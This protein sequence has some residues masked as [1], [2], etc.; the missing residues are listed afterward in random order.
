MSEMKT[1]ILAKNKAEEYVKSSMH[2]FPSDI[3]KIPAKHSWFTDYVHSS[4]ALLILVS[5]N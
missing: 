1:S 5:Q 4:N 2:M 3:M